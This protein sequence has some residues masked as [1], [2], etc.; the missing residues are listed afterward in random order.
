MTAGCAAAITHSTAAC[1]AGRI[2]RRCSACPTHGLKNEV[3]MPRHSRNVYDHAVRMS[4]V[5]IVEV[6]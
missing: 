1:I 4:G 2:R 6:E 3:I 5:K